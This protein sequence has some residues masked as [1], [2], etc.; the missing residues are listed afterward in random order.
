VYPSVEDLDNAIHALA[1]RLASS[2][3]E[4][5]KMLKQILWQGTDEWDT[6]LEHRAA[7]SGKLVLSDFTREA[8]GRFKTGKG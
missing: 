1:T 5:M 6:L 8:I 2:N 4:A 3:P 7:M